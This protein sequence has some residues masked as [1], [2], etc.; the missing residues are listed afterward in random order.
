MTKRNQCAWK[1][2]TCQFTSLVELNIC[3]RCNDIKW[4]MMGKKQKTSKIELMNKRI[5]SWCCK[6]C[7]N[8][9]A[10]NP[11]KSECPY[12][13]SKKYHYFSS[14]KEADRF[15]ELML[16]EFSNN[17]SELDTQPVFPIIINEQKICEYRADFSYR[18]NKTGK[19]IVEDVKAKSKK[20]GA[21]TTKEFELKRKLIK[22]IYNIDIVIV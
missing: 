9:T 17:I 15:K 4:Q 22:A 3:P 14:Q 20:K 5:P 7:K 10:I 13:L 21:I 8:W 18:D 2:V 1:C 12:C 11:K 6:K 16:L 19:T